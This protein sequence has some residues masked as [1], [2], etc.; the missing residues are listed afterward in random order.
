MESDHANQRPNAGDQKTND[1]ESEEKADDGAIWGFGRTKCQCNRKHE[2]ANPNQGH[3]ARLLDL[4][5]R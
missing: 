1:T 2:P 5:K 4:L 3:A